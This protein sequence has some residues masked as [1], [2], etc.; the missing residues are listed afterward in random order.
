MDDNR[1]TWQLVLEVAQRLTAAGTATMRLVEIVEGVQAI[2]PGRGG[3]SIRPTVQGMT[4]N[5]GQGPPA[6]CGKV[7]ERVGRGLYELIG[8]FHRAVGAPASSPHLRR[9]RRDLTSQVHQ[10]ITGFDE[11]V[12]AYDRLVP[13][14]RSGQYD[15]H[16]ATIDRRREVGSPGAAAHD[17][18][19]ATLLHS[20]LQAWGIGR[21]ASRLLPITDF[22]RRLAVAAP[23]LDE[24]ADQRIDD[25]DLDVATVAASVDR[26][27][28]TVGVVENRAL[29]V[30]GTKTLHHLLPDL[31]PP[32]DRAYTGAFFGWNTLDPQNRQTAIFTEAFTCLAEVAVAVQPQRLVGKGWRTSVTKLLDN[33]LI[34]LGRSETEAATQELLA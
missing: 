21:R 28:S 15:L 29:I 17:P 26:L 27:I 14:T 25:S 6:P 31:V 4:A 33:A 23:A 1:P 20:T 34:G 2:D 10:L 19:F 3:S 16:R 7:F 5:V 9:S 30:A 13:F 32:M 12:D 22:R 8:T 11:Y 18:V 24:L